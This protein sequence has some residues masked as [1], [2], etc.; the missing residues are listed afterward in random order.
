MNR[1]LQTEIL[2]FLE[3]HYKDKNI[4]RFTILLELAGNDENELIRELSYLEERG[5]IHSGLISCSDGYGYNDSAIEITA[6]GLDYMQAD[7]GLREALNVVTVKL[8]PTT[9]AALESFLDSASPDKSAEM[10]ARLKQLPAYAIEQ[11]VGKL[12]ELGLKNVPDAL[13]LIRSLL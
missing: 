3:R 11:L 12:V 9:L 8:H 6:D 1:S 4:E 5:L 10:K 2:L 7:G 13:S